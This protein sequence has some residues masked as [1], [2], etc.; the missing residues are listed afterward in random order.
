LVFSP[1]SAQ[2]TGLFVTTNVRPVWATPA[3]NWATAPR[4]AVDRHPAPPDQ[5]DPCEDERRRA[6]DDPQRGLRQLAPRRHPR[7]PGMDCLELVLDDGEVGASLMELSLREA[8]VWYEDG[9][10]DTVYRSLTR[11]SAPGD[12]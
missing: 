9:L 2:R 1:V 3:M 7:E 12:L 6:E 4:R 10:Q 11:P 8:F 5:L